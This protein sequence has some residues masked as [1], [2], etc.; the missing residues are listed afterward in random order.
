MLRLGFLAVLFA[1]LGVP[2][3]AAAQTTAVTTYVLRLA[4]QNGAPCAAPDERDVAA[5]A[6]VVRAKVPGAML[7]GVT[8][9]D[10]LGDA[11]AAVRGSGA[12]PRLR[13]VIASLC[14]NGDVNVAT[15]RGYDLA[16]AANE[17]V[18][19][20]TGTP[21]SGALDELRAASWATLFANPSSP[22]AES[23]PYEPAVG[24]LA[25]T[26]NARLERTLPLNEVDQPSPPLTLCRSGAYHLL[27]MGLASAATT[28]Q[29]PVRAAL[30]ALAASSFSQPGPWGSVY[31]ITGAL[32]PVV[33][34][35]TS[36]EAGVEMFF[37]DD[38]GLHQ[39]GGRGHHVVGHAATL[40]IGTS[41]A[42]RRR[43][44]TRAV[45]DL[46]NQVGCVLMRYLRETNAVGDVVLAADP[47]AS[48]PWCKDYYA[49]LR[50]NAGLVM[51]SKDLLLAP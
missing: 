41:S 7:A 10:P 13:I 36:A 5:V 49:A 6:G 17:R 14:K 8:V 2:G 20:T 15:I 45:D 26:V 1:A 34:V 44:V 31:K 30:G 16:H 24:D 51:T 4:A 23:V 46:R 35:P 50:A 38:A 19:V 33:G 40:T 43:I 28:N 29:D 47:I 18:T 32:V 25:S 37:C 48:P 3:P 11:V 9:A 12:P 22:P 21:V 39:F 27:V 42:V